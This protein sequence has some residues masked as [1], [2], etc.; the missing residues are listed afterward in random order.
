[1][2]IQNVPVC[3]FKTFP[4]E[5]TTCPHVQNM[6]ASC[7]YTRERFERTHGDVLNAHTGGGRETKGRGGHRQF[8]IPKIWPRRVIT[9]FRGSPTETF[10]SIQGLR[11]SR[12]QHFPDS[13]NHSLYLIK[14]FTSS[15]P[16][17]NFGECAT[18]HTH[19]THT[20]S[21]HTQP[22]HTATQHGTPHQHI[23]HGDRERRQRNREKRR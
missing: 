9:C 21:T 14:L 7:R 16:E 20:H 17:G 12:E 22:Q 8:Y 23:Q 10:G 6:W 2:C 3:A 11:T 5:P 1:M 13:S 15:S 4:C 18:S 19:T